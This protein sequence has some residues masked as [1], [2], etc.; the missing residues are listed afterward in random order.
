MM[1]T[2]CLRVVPL[3]IQYIIIVMWG[4]EPIT[5]S[6]DSINFD[7][8]MFYLS[9]ITLCLGNFCAG[10]I[11]TATF[12]T[13]MTL[14]QSAETNIQTS[15]YSLLATM[16]VMG[17]LMFASV[18]GAMID[19]VGLDKVFILFVILAILTVPLL[20]WMPDM[21]TVKPHCDKQKK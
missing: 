4:T 21:N 16:E 5:N 19:A 10:L 14:S 12:T 1:H 20:L 9:I 17:K 13:M 18:A 2:A 6:L 7:S 15:H 11:T 8:I 3:S